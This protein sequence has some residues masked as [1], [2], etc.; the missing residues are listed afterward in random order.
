MSGIVKNTVKTIL[1]I[2][3]T[4][5][6]FQELFLTVQFTEYDFL[7][8]GSAQIAITETE[9]KKEILLLSLAMVIVVFYL[10]FSINIKNTV[11]G[12]ILDILFLFLPLFFC[13]SANII[14]NLS[15]SS[16]LAD[17]S[18]SYFVLTRNVFYLNML[19][20]IGTHHIFK[21]IKIIRTNTIKA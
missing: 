17:I 11:Y 20:F 8:S 5:I 1:F 4:I 15:L 10:L 13:W 2:V 6:F 9:F 3:L 14:G 16:N 18:L 12:F 7:S 19:V 21:L